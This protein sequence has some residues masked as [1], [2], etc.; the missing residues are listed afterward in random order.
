MNP[1]GAGWQELEPLLDAVLE[2]L[3]EVT[4]TEEPRHD[5]DVGTEEGAEWSP[6]D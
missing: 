4:G 6:L 3:P 2:Y 5:P 1:T